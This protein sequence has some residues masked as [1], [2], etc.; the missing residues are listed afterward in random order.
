MSTMLARAVRIACAIRPHRLR[1]P[2]ATSVP[3]GGT[4]YSNG[5]NSLFHGLEQ[6]LSLRLSKP[7]LRAFGAFERI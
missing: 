1:E 5:W 3:W 6:R 4:F 7:L 2:F